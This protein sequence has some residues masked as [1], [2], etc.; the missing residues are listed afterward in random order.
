MESYSS[1]ASFDAADLEAGFSGSTVNYRSFYHPK[2][3]NGS[4]GRRLSSDPFDGV[5]DAHHFLHACF[6]CKKLLHRNGDIFMY[7]GDTPFCSEECREEQIKM[8]E[9]EEKNRNKKSSRGF[10]RKEQQQ[11]SQRI[12]VSAW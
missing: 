7:R 6:L 10:S 1:Y 9:D 3:T 11:S 12:P 4:P 8:D 5:D 2:G